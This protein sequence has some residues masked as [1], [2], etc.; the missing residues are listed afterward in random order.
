MNEAGDGLLSQSIKV[1][2]YLRMLRHISG[3]PEGQFILVNP[4]II[5]M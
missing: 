1:S 4:H 5:K 2:L 3:L